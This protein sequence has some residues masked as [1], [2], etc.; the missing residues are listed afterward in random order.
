LVHEHGADLLYLR[1]VFL[2]PAGLCTLVDA[3][4]VRVFGRS[5]G[6]HSALALSAHWRELNAELAVLTG[7]FGPPVGGS[8]PAPV[9]PGGLAGSSAGVVPKEERV[10]A[11]HGDASTGDFLEPDVDSA[12][13][14][15]PSPSPGLTTHGGGGPRPARAPEP[16]E[17]RPLRGGSASR[18]L[19]S[20]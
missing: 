6:T 3:Q 1:H 14:A 9:H 5:A 16:G 4:D 11:A 7:P 19:D 10:D 13:S 17:A 18:L 2:L 8:A 15:P 12:H 20:P